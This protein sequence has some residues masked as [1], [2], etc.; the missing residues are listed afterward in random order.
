MSCIMEGPNEFVLDGRLATEYLGLECAF[1]YGWGWGNQQQFPESGVS[2]LRSYRTSLISTYRF[3]HHLPIR[4]NESFDL[5]IDWRGEPHIN[6]NNYWGKMIKHAHAI[7]GCWVD[8]ATVH[9]WYQDNPGGFE[10]AELEPLELRSKTIAKR[11]Y[12]LDEQPELK[13]ES[14]VSDHDH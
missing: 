4:F 14:E 12:E 6:G 1:N 8:M 5:C 9:Y 7:G 11:P 13:A 10:H 2:L 3:H